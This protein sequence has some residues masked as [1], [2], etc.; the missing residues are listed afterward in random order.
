[1]DGIMRNDR[2][3]GDADAP[4]L[5]RTQPDPLALCLDYR[6]AAQKLE[7]IKSMASSPRMRTMSTRKLTS[8]GRKKKNI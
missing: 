4:C 8:R 7:A 3:H 6:L 1:M 2:R 5:A